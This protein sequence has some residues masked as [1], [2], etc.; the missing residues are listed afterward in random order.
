[1]SGLSFE[2]QVARA[3]EAVDDMSLPFG[4]L[5]LLWLL[6]TERAAAA[7]SDNTMRPTSEALFE[8]IKAAIERGDSLWPD[9]VAPLGPDIART[10]R[11]RLLTSL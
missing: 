4:K 1:M 7:G 2:A 6:A 10:V 3:V 5:E 8:A 9:M 11:A